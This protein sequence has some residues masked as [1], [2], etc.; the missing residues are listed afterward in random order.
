[1]SS[2][3]E[4]GGKPEKTWACDCLFCRTVIWPLLNLMIK[5]HKRGEGEKKE[6]SEE[7]KREEKEV[8]SQEEIE[9]LKELV[10]ALRESIIE[11]KSTISDITSPF[12]IMKKPGEEEEREEKKKIEPEL[13]PLSG[14]PTTLKI[15]T[16][17]TVPEK[18]RSQEK[19]VVKEQPATQSTT[20]PTM[21]MEKKETSRI[22]EKKMDLRKALKMLRMLYKLSQKI[23]GESLDYY[24]KL[25]QT[26][27]LTDENTVETIMTLKKIVEQSGKAGMSPEDQ[28]IAIYSLAKMLGIEDPELEEEI[29][30]L[31]IEKL[32]GGSGEWVHQQQ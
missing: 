3:E 25:F 28:I 31:M 29:T 20:Q 10:E 18:P 19:P 7:E 5:P 16:S 15:P 11:L 27:G 22:I 24:I 8:V 4:A 26:L 23:P 9:N 30:M 12:S 13:P 21:T 1:M 2:H 6:M 17:Y 32:R 14:S